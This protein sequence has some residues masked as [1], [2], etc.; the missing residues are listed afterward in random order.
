L[1]ENVNALFPTSRT[2]A[3]TLKPSGGGVGVAL[4]GY[5]DSMPRVYESEGGAFSTRTKTTEHRFTFAAADAPNVA[6]GD[7]VERGGLAYEVLDTFSDGTIATLI[8][9][10]GE[11]P[12]GRLTTMDGADLLTAMD[13]GILTEI[14]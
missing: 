14:T 9:A 5:W 13:G 8:L 10:D 7:I 3:A 11:T 1:P 4:R 12:I 2:V 6:E